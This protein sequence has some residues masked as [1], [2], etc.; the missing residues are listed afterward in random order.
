MCV[1]VR[2]E[3][4]II[5]LKSLKWKQIFLLWLQQ[6][7]IFARELIFS[8]RMTALIKSYLRSCDIITADHMSVPHRVR[9]GR[10]VTLA[11]ALIFT[12]RSVVRNIIIA[13]HLSLSVLDRH[14]VTCV[15]ICMP[16]RGRCIARWLSVES[17]TRTILATFSSLSRRSRRA[18]SIEKCRGTLEK[19]C[20]YGRF[21]AWN[22]VLARSRMHLIFSHC[23]LSIQ[24]RTSIRLG[25]AL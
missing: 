5:K 12:V 6:Q 1:C 25:R 15:H 16:S 2:R 17:R 13:T 24:F 21:T 4:V 10:L 3:L 11:I 20:V 23:S 9:I 7:R 19:V 8:P 14:A 18:R 22:F